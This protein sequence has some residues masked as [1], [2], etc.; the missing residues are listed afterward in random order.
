[1]FK[2]LNV[3]VTTLVAIFTSFHLFAQEQDVLIAEIND[4]LKENPEIVAPLHQNLV[5][6]LDQSR[7]LAEKIDSYQELFH[8]PDQPYFGNKDGELTIV[9]FYDYSCPF[10]KRLEPELE[11][12]VKAYPNVKVI[13]MLMP[14][15]E[16]GNTENSAA[17]AMNVWKHDHSS[18]SETH[19]LLVKKRGVHNVRSVKSVAKKTSTEA[20]LEQDLE[21][22]SR[23]AQNYQVFIDLGMRG[24]PA[25]I[26][27]DEIV[28]GYVPFERLKQ[29]VE[30]KL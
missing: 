19:E 24:T 14:L 21:T 9:A 1:M 2:K 26:I 12:V 6:Y 18:F 15:K 11:K 22:E 3:L 7:S 28:S 10:C 17:L 27:G 13:H 29:V 20:A 30:A 4:I 5:S 23:L 8:H 16:Q 25:M